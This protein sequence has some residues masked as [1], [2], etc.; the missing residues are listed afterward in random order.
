MHNALYSRLFNF[1]IAACA[2]AV[3]PVLAQQLEISAIQA[4]LDQTREQVTQLEFSYGRLDRRLLEPLDLFNQQLVDAE[5]FAEAHTVLNHVIQITRVSEGLYSQTQL[6]FLVRRIENLGNLRDWEEARESMEHLSWLLSRNENVIDEVLIESMVNLADLHLWGVA[7]DF[8][9]MQGFHFKAAE[10]INNL[11]IR[12][13]ATA[14]GEND[15]RLPAIIYKAVIQKYLQAVAVDV[16]GSTGLSLRAYSS[17]GAARSRSDARILRY[18]SGLRL[19]DSIRRV[20]ANQEPP[21]LEGLALAEMYVADWQ[22]LFANPDAS[23]IA[24][25]RSNDLLL[26]AGIEQSAINEFF[27]QPKMLP[28]PEFL[29]SFDEAISPLADSEQADLAHSTIPT[30]NFKQWSASFTYAVALVEYGVYPD[31]DNEDDEFAMFSFNLSGLEV[32][33]RWYRGQY[34]K[35][36]SVAQDLQLLDQQFFQPVDWEELEHRIKEVRFRPKLVNGIPQTVN[37]TLLYRLASE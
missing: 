10:R 13:A 25:K 31:F 24:Y 20:Y 6:P 12:A 34:K 11:A 21:D 8:A 3:T 2:L 18:Y 14:W 4:D 30:L 23:E 15:R 29:A 19:L 7:D 33:T 5:R 27:Q 32:V 35:S 37:T 17:T 22:V 9:R 26:L 1:A 36:I 28:A 16:G